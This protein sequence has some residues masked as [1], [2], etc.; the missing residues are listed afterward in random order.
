[1]IQKFTVVKIAANEK[2]CERY[3]S[4]AFIYDIVFVKD[5]RGR[6]YTGAVRRAH[7]QTLKPGS[8]FMP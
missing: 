2:I 3:V 4:V 8:G 7:C 1:M 6:W 5:H